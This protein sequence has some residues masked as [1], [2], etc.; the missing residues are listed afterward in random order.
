MHPTTAHPDPPIA[1]EGIAQPFGDVAGDVVK[2][3]GVRAK[4]AD[5]RREGKAVI[6]PRL[7]VSFARSARFDAVSSPVHQTV[8][9]PARAAYSHWSPVGKTRPRRKSATSQSDQLTSSTG[10]RSVIDWP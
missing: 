8:V 4:A 10:W 6:E 7:D 5:R 3:E 1:R 9:V 2:T